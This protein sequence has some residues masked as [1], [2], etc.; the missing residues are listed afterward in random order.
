MVAM[1]LWGV[2]LPPD[3]P[4][5]TRLHEVVVITNVAL[6][7]QLQDHE[8]R[9]SVR[10]NVSMENKYENSFVLCSLT[11]GKVEQCSVNL[12]LLADTTYTFQSIGPNTVYLSGNYVDE[13]GTIRALRDVLSPA[14]LEA[15]KTARSADRPADSEAGLATVD[16][17]SAQPT[18][19]IKKRRRNSVGETSTGGDAQKPQNKA[20]EVERP[21]PKLEG[22]QWIDS[23][24][25]GRGDITVKWGDEVFLK[26]RMVTSNNGVPVAD[27]I[28]GEPL[29]FV[30][31]DKAAPIPQGMKLRAQRLVR[32]SLE[33]AQKDTGLSVFLKP[34]QAYRID[35]FVWNFTSA[36]LTASKA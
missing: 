11:P 32:V 14:L 22:V 9:T 12:A 1:G 26:Y 5:T 4:Y 35:L 21:T 24:P 2:C 3:T 17:A 13:F 34:A 16:P 19:N 15:S 31:G 23:G 8:S 25:S 30:V 33:S 27:N 7:D 36:P 18:T 28:S 10:I 29:H 6:T 20:K